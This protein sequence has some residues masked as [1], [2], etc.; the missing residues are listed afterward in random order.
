[1]LYCGSEITLRNERKAVPWSIWNYFMSDLFFPV[2]LWL[3]PWFSTV[4][5][6]INTQP[7]QVDSEE[8]KSPS[9]VTDSFSLSLQSDHD[10]LCSLMHYCCCNF[11]RIN[12]VKHAA[13]YWDSLQSV[14]GSLVETVSKGGFLLGWIQTA[15]K[16]PIM[17]HIP[18]M[19]HSIRSGFNSS[20]HQLQLFSTARD[21]IKNSSDMLLGYRLPWKDDATVMK[22]EDV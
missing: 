6:S 10:E 3:T 9:T 15:M 4:C 2:P 13:F 8:C 19:L 16:I 18:C 14:P 17:F 12:N 20:T 5:Q 1:M 21:Q 22:W 7:L 11:S